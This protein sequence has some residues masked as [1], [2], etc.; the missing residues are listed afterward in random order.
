MSSPF[1][2]FN[3]AFLQIPNGEGTLV[4][5]PETG[6]YEQQETFIP[7]QAILMVKNSPLTIRTEGVDNSSI[8]VKGYLIDPMVF[9]TNFS[10]PATV[11]CSFFDIDNRVTKGNLE[12]NIIPDP[13]KVGAITGQRL[14]GTFTVE[15]RGNENNG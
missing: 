9:P 11:A 5:N 3:N 10:L 7:Y 2:G 13:F 12:L 4:I 8:E 6:N 14:E 1:T 15:G